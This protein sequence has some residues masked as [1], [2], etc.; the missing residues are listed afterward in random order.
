MDAVIQVY[1]DTEEEW[2]SVESVSSYLLNN[3]IPYSL[4]M[5]IIHGKSEHVAIY[6]ATITEQDAMFLTLKYP[7]ITI[8][9]VNS[10]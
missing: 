5:E 3:F 10:V 1:A 8:I 4:R 6:R 9:P 2:E 7:N